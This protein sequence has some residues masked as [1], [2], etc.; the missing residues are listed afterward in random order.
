MYFFFF[1][2]IF[3]AQHSIDLE[4]K[5]MYFSYNTKESQK[6]EFFPDTRHKDNPTYRVA[7][8]DPR[9]LQKIKPYL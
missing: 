7:G 1:N 5:K 2:Y 8:T 9:G 4:G 3:T 6:R